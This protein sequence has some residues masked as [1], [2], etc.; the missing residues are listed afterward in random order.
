MGKPA[1]GSV[2]AILILGKHYSPVMLGTGEH[3]GDHG[4][5]SE[6]LLFVTLRVRRE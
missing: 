6:Q 5:S 2:A 3:A 4:N 1:Y